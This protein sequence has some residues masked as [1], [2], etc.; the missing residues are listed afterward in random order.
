MSRASGCACCTLRTTRAADVHVGRHI[1]A[2]GRL[3]ATKETLMKF[4]LACECED[5]GRWLADASELPGLLACGGSAN[6]AMT[7]AEILALRVFAERLEKGEAQPQEINISL[8]A[9][10]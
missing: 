1:L 7:K 6:E 2:R 9:A 3:R 4:T 10:A 8:P 5:D